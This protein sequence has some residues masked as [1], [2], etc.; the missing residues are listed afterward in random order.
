MALYLCF[1]FFLL[2]LLS[3]KNAFYFATK[4][5]H[6]VQRHNSVSLST[7]VLVGHGEPRVGKEITA[8]QR[9]LGLLAYT[10]SGCTIPRRQGFHG[11]HFAPRFASNVGT[12]PVAAGS[13][14]STFASNFGSPDTREP[15]NTV[16]A[17]RRFPPRRIRP[18][19]TGTS[20]QTQVICAPLEA[21]CPPK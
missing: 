19:G 17:A 18:L 5:A 11:S 3:R 16:A 2:I 7:C 13:P 10:G 12:S 15:S 8:Q 4:A 6:L 21:R 9:V 20:T 1:F 14:H